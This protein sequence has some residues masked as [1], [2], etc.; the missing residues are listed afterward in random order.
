LWRFVEAKGTPS[1]AVAVATGA[2]LQQHLEQHQQQQQ[3][4]PSQPQLMD[5]MNSMFNIG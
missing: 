5:P 4:H 2:G 3:Q 1:S